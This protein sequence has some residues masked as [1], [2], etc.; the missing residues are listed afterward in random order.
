MTKFVVIIGFLV[1]FA[2]GVM[3]GSI[4]WRKGDDVN[5]AV[6]TTAPTT[7]H[8]RGGLLQSELGLTSEQRQAMDKIWSE[9]AGRGRGEQEE[10]R[11]QF[12]RER[13]EAIA[14][15]IPDDDKAKLE[16]IG[17]EYTEKL[18][19][20]DRESR[21]AFASAV[22]QTK[23]LLTPEQRVKYDELLKRHH[24]DRGPGPRPRNR[25][26]NFIRNFYTALERSLPCLAESGFPL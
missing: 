21:A 19:A 17:A 10:K 9:M 12:R 3:V 15:L 25:H 13:D 1:A 14:A 2:A 5:G 24:W 4:D 7:R 20:L 8:S 22:E 18:A 23:A 16:Q 26:R 6:A 11:R